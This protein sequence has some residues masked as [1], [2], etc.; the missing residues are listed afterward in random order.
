MGCHLDLPV[1]RPRAD[2]DKLPAFPDS[3]AATPLKKTFRRSGGYQRSVERDVASGEVVQRVVD[4]TGAYT[5]DHIGLDYELVQEEVS[6][7][8]PDDP[9]SARVDV[10]CTMR[11]GRGDW[12]TRSE[13]RTRLRATETEFVIDASLDAYEGD[14]RVV[15]RNW[16]R[17]IKRDLV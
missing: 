2:D 3:E 13:T 11:I 4:D 12:R 17:R 5:I 9:L 14:T 16:S 1:R 6:R 15:A 7:I 8:R 10:S